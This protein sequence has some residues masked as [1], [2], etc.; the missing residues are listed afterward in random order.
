[1][2]RQ[3]LLPHAITSYE[4]LNVLQGVGKRCNIKRS[5]TMHESRVTGVPMKN[6]NKHY[7]VTKL[8]NKFYLKMVK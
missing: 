5:F 7:M 3:R 6:K 8:K 2:Y 4:Y 1:M